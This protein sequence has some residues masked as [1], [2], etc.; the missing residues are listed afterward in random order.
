MTR[1]RSDQ[2]GQVL[3][4]AAAVM[5]L[6]FVPLAVF[7]I[8]SGLMEAGHAQ[9]G[10]TVQAS[11]EDGAS[12]IDQAV[13]RQSGGQRVVLDGPAARATSER[14]LRSSGLPDLESWTVTVQ[15]NSVTVSATLQ[16]RL[17]FVG[18]ATVHQTRSATF[19]YGS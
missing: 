1:R 8:D 4:M 6:L 16:V 17:L 12:M 7:V 2:D 18:T 10:E 19:V 15:G 3:L 13:F 11:A 9:L 5:A 14:S